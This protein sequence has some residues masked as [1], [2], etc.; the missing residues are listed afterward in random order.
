MHYY[1]YEIRNN[2]NG[3]IYVGVHKTKNLDDGYM[4]S[5]ERINAAI[6]K[7]GIDNFTKIILQER[8]SY[9]EVLDLEKE[10]VND[11]FL[12]RQDV[13]NIRRGGVGGFSDFHVERANEARQ[14]KLKERQEEYYKDPVLCEHCRTVIQ[15]E[16]RRS[17][18][19]CKSC[20]ASRNNSKRVRSEESKLKCSSTLT[21][22][23]KT[24]E[25]KKEISKGRLKG[26]EDRR[27][28]LES[29]SGL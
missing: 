8:S 20:S 28:S 3:K 27:R 16:K 5:G 21:G 17:K 18:F 23:P 4:G 13:Y 1:L 22:V 2:L 24:E 26:L 29:R 14:Q 25:H 7:Y 19:C 9:Q 11:E 15:Y 10:I 6:A 12:K